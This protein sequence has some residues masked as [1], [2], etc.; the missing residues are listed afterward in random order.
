MKAAL[1]SV[2]AFMHHADTACIMLIL[3]ECINHACRIDMMH[4]CSP[5]ESTP[6][7]LLMY[8]ADSSGV[9]QPCGVVMTLECRTGEL[10][11]RAA[12]MFQEVN[13]KPHLISTFCTSQQL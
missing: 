12:F 1:V 7:R 11:A 8:H 3:Q 4:G 2:L 5:G 9:Y 10:L 13:L 6:R